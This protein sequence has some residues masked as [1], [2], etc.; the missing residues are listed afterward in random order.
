MVNLWSGEIKK[1]AKITD[2]TPVSTRW[3]SRQLLPD[4]TLTCMIRAWEC[5]RWWSSGEV[6][7]SNFATSEIARN[8]LLRPFV[9]S[10]PHSCSHADAMTG[11]SKRTTIRGW[12]QQLL[13]AQVLGH[14]TP[15]QAAAILRPGRSLFLL[16]YNEWL[17]AWR[18]RF[19][20]GNTSACLRKEK[21]WHP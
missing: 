5:T 20:S 1:N 14:G 17:P 9:T 3:R 8:E 18:A 11:N 7:V 12:R 21:A 15:V 19:K 4:R 16:G 10:P 2:C 13:I 6:R